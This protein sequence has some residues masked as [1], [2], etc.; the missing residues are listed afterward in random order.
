MK[1]GRKITKDWFVSQFMNLKKYRNEEEFSILFEF[2]HISISKFSFCNSYIE[3]IEKKKRKK[4]ESSTNTDDWC[5]LGWNETKKKE[6]A[7]NYF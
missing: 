7:N 4:I 5:E 3:N 1:T 2:H 6:K